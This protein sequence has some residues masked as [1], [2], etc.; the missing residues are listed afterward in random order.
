MNDIHPVETN[1]ASQRDVITLRDYERCPTIKSND[2]VHTIIG[3]KSDG[4]SHSIEAGKN[5]NRD[6][7]CKPLENRTVGVSLL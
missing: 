6:N 3:V 2:V 1:L 5:H 7:H 4:M